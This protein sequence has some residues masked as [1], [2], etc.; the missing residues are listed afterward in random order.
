MWPDFTRLPNEDSPF[1]VLREQTVGDT[2]EI[3]TR[4]FRTVEVNHV[5]PAVGYLVSNA[6]GTIAFSGDTTTTDAF[7][8]TVNACGDLRYVIVETTFLDRDAELAVLSR[9]LCPA[10]LAEQ[11][12]RYR[13]EAPVFI[14]H[15][16]PGM[17]S[18]IMREI[19]RHVPQGTPARLMRGQV[20]NI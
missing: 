11:L 15:L 6:G 7:W 10:M 5:V 4:R 16:M 14:T 19:A 18:A 17:E 9:H 2:V 3:G 1:V 8:D 12:A 13:G 20:L